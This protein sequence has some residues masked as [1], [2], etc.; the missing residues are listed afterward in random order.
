MI[1][2]V[3]CF[4]CHCLPGGSPCVKN[5]VLNQVSLNPMVTFHQMHGN[6]GELS[7]ISYHTLN[8]GT[9]LGRPQ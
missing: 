5:P 2:S 1:N 9:D 8:P 6:I 4:L 7:L 3:N